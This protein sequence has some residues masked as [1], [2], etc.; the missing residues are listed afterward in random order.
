MH[1]YNMNMNMME[2]SFQIEKKKVFSCNLLFT[3]GYFVD[4]RPCFNF[5]IWIMMIV[6]QRVLFVE[7]VRENIFREFNTTLV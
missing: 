3:C 2:K 1:E 7:K 5:L 6:S 4:C